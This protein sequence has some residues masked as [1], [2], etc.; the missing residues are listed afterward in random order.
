MYFSSKAIIRDDNKY[1]LQLRDNK[2]SIV[3]PNRWAFFGGR[4]KKNETAEKCLI[5]ELKEELSLKIKITMKLYEQFNFKK[6]G[7]INYFYVEHLNKVRKLNL[8]EG[9]DLGWF[10]KSEIKKLN[11]ADDVKIIIDYI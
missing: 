11:L 5:R 9:Q 10:R 7:R 1:L 6:E 4:F 2:K 3:Y 8:K